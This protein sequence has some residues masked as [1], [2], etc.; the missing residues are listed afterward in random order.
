MRPFLDLFSLLSILKFLA[1]WMLLLSFALLAQRRLLS[2]IHLL[3]W[4]GITLA[5]STAMVAVLT[6]DRLLWVSATLTLSLKGLLIPFLL[7]RLL[8]R[9]QVRGDVEM[10]LNVASVQLLGIVLVIFAFALAA[11][12][13]GSLP[14]ATHGM[15]GIA[16]AAFLLAFLMMI[17]RR[18]AISEVV[19]F[20]AM[21]NALFFAA[22]SATL[23]MPLIVELGIALDALIAFLIL[24]VF[25][26]HIRES[27]E[28]LDLHWLEHLRENQ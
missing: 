25:F 9:L 3:A 17:T 11:P 14:A 12:L 4:Q 26:F 27:F 8:R 18:K 24:G 6:G 19:G 7:H 15:L 13:A 28:N 5:L 22:T 21:D 1:A 2:L 10:S 16:L 20:L 23:G